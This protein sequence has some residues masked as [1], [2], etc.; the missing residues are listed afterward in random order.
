ML[1]V[2]CKKQKQK[3]LK[4]VIKVAIPVRCADGDAL[5]VCEFIKKVLNGNILQPFTIL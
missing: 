4:R 3:E 5:G 2:L 1:L